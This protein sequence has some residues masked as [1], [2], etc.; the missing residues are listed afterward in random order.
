M[1]G[2]II[3]AA[4][5]SKRFGTPKQLAEFR[6]KAL[7]RQAA[8]TAVDAQL[9]PVTV[10]L[11]AVDQ[12]CREV[13]AGL[14]VSIVHNPEWRNGMGSSIVAG[15]RSCE[16]MSPDGVIIMLAD[17]PGVTAE[18][19]RALDAAST[20]KP[21]V[22]S[23][24]DGQLGVPAWFSAAKFEQMLELEGE[25]GAK[26]LIAREPQVHEIEMPAA[27]FDVDTPT[28][29]LRLSQKSRL[30]RG[31][32]GKVGRM[33][34]T[35]ISRATSA[36]PSSALPVTACRKHPFGTSPMNDSRKRGGSHA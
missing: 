23:R 33:V 18:H 8:E 1:T 35:G 14:E 13:L 7:L 29:L 26:A 31:Q 36:C 2:I 25:K 3:L 19:L 12:A 17:Q 30:K 4:G 28:D 34:S 20:A 11:G 9:G 21:I 15:M 10:V 16:G 5:E 32:V 24:Y 6:G 22:A 27:A